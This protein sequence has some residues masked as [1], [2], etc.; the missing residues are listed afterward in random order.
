M[1]ERAAQVLCGDVLWSHAV[2]FVG[3]HGTKLMPSSPQTWKDIP[4]GTRKKTFDTHISLCPP[5]CLGV[6][7]RAYAKSQ[8]HA[9]G[10]RKFVAQKCTTANNPI[11]A[12]QSTTENQP[13]GNSIFERHSTPNCCSTCPIIT[14]VVAIM[15]CAALFNEVC[16]DWCTVSCT[17]GLAETS[18]SSLVGP[19]FAAPK[20]LERGAATWVGAAPEPFA[21]WAAVAAGTLVATAEARLDAGPSRTF[22]PR[23]W[24][25]FA[26]LWSF[27]PVVVAGVAVARAAS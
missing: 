3:D 27:V 1:Q 16:P 14:S 23:F 18:A 7:I 19:L 20:M 4:R 8:W 6:S 26:G 2:D 22:Q 5:L 11:R 15:S 13:V 9:A 12:R 10:P 21:A 25:D 17:A 24:L